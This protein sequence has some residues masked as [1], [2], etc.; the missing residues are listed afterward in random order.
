MQD[1]T[2]ARTQDDDDVAPPLKT[3]HVVWVVIV[4]LLLFL[5][6]VILIKKKREK[7]KEVEI[8]I[9]DATTPTTIIT[10]PTYDESEDLGGA[11]ST[12]VANPTYE[13][14]DLHNASAIVRNPTY[15]PS[16]NTDE[17]ASVHESTDLL[18]GSSNATGQANNEGAIPAVS[19][20]ESSALYDEM[21]DLEVQGF[22]EGGGA[23]VYAETAQM[24][25]V[26][27]KLYEAQMGMQE[28]IDTSGHSTKHF[29]DEHIN[30]NMTPEDESAYGGIYL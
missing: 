16:S 25:T 6:I 22:G 23:T 28:P 27:P 29:H 13:S 7:E 5:A 3:P 21:A 10:N 11:S 24:N 4:L 26:D 9:S 12:I 18:V 14:E 15:E 19:G 30:L 1:C 2:P 17:G 20:S 8:L